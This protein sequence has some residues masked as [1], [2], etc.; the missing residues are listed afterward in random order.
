MQLLVRNEIKASLAND[1]E[2]SLFIDPLLEED[3]VGAV[4]IDLRLG[5][6]FLVSVL[7][8]KPFVAIYRENDYRSISSYFQ[9][10]RRELGDRFVLYPNQVVLTTTLEYLSL[11]SDVYADI[12]TRS[13]Y[14]RLGISISTMLQPGFRGCAPIELFNH[15]NNAV[16]LVVGSRMFQA[17]LT[18]LDAKARYLDGRPRKYYGDVRPTVSRASHDKDLDRLYK[19]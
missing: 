1:D 17:R 2:D 18:R 13:S 9:N 15:G 16:E 10:T 8:R 19:A 12:M 11:P 14:N 4:T 7:T 5:Y 6:D 3:Q